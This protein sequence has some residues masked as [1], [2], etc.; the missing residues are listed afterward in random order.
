MIVDSDNT[1]QNALIRQLSLSEIDAVFVHVGIPD[2]YLLDSEHSV[3]PRN[4]VR[5]FKA[6]YYSTFLTPE[7][8]EKALDLAT[9]TQEE[10]LISKGV[11]SQIQVAHK[12]GIVNEKFLHDCGIIYH[13]KNPYFLCI[14][15]KNMLN[16]SYD[17]IPEISKDV[18]DYVDSQGH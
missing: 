13:Q 18:Y 14:M 10:D 5:F 9:D 3:S 2:P 7:Y 8:S 4:Y 1:A 11:P 17:I 6:L 16:E 12:F 15:T